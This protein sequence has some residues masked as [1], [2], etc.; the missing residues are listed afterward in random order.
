MV[1]IKYGL[2]TFTDK[3]TEARVHEVTHPSQSVDQSV[4]RMTLETGGGPAVLRI[5]CWPSTTF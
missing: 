2:L 1:S 3:K 4:D 5:S